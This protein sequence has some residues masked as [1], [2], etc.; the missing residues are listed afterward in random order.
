MPPSH[1]DVAVTQYLN[2]FA[3]RSANFDTAVTLLSESHAFKGGVICV[4]IWALWFVDDAKVSE[5]R[6]RLI[7]T[8]LACLV[9][10]M[11]ARLCVNVLPFRP[12]PFMNKELGF[13]LPI[14]MERDSLGDWSSLPSDHA[15]WFF[16][17][18]AGLWLVDR[19]WG[20]L[21]LL[22][23]T[24]VIGLPRIYLGYHYATDILSG[25]LIGIGAAAG[26]WYLARRYQFVLRPFEWLQAT[27]AWLFYAGLFLVTFQISEM[28]DSARRIG[29]AITKLARVLI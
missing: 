4:L 9:A 10:M 13:Q 11:V 16:S 1:F 8:F 27:R 25:A 15:A 5:R 17:L 2:H 12:R 21:A 18:A 19:R 3:R 6:K 24:F 29:S 26:C 23:A 14:G 28:F 22:H 7:T 20:L